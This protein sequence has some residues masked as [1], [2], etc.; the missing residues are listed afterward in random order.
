[1][2]YIYE[3]KATSEAQKEALKDEIRE[4]IAT[5]IVNWT[6]EKKRGLKQKVEN[7]T[8]VVNEDDIF[9]IK[10]EEKAYY[11]LDE[12]GMKLR[13][14]FCSMFCINE[15][16]EKFVRSVLLEKEILCDEFACLRIALKPGYQTLNINSSM[17]S[18]LDLEIYNDKEAGEVL[19]LLYRSD[20][21]DNIVLVVLPKTSRYQ[22]KVRK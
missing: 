21:Y 9:E 12:E 7:I 6:A 13:V 1:M 8:A 4:K 2:L 15:K 17:F 18:I 3:E 11:L 10:D 16:Y 22:L 20:T 5:K 14:P 19:F